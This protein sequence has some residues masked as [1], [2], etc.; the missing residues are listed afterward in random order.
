MQ[1]CTNVTKPKDCGGLEDEA[2]FID[3]E[4][5]FVI[6]RLAQIASSVVK[7]CKNRNKGIM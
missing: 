7:N 3:T 1:L 2:F 5:S 4:G 6:Q